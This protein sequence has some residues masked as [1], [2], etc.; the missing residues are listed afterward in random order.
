MQRTLPSPPPDAVERKSL[1]ETGFI[2]AEWWTY[3]CRRTGD[4]CGSA[5]VPRGWNMDADHDAISGE[6]LAQHA[7]C[8]ADAVNAQTEQA[9][10]SV[11]AEALVRFGTRFLDTLR[12]AA[13]AAGSPF[14]ELCNEAA[15]LFARWIAGERL[16]AR[17]DEPERRVRAAL[18]LLDSLDSSDLEQLAFLQRVAA[19]TVLALPQGHQERDA[20]RARDVLLAYLRRSRDKGDADEQVRTL[21][22]L[23]DH[24][25][26]FPEGIDSLV[27]EGL[28]LIDDARRA[29]SID[30]E[31]RRDF[32]TGTLLYYT[33]RL[34]QDPQEAADWRARVEAAIDRVLA[35]EP[36]PGDLYAANTYGSVARALEVLGRR[37]SAAEH[38]RR[39]VELGDLDKMTTQWAVEGECRM[40]MLLLAE[41]QEEQEREADFRRVTGLLTDAVPRLQERY[42]TAVLDEDIEKSGRL[43]AKALDYLAFA[44]ARQGA[45][46]DALRYLDIGKSLRLRHRYALRADPA[47]QSLL[48]LE[49]ALHAVLRGVP[50]EIFGV[51]EAEPTDVLGAASSAR[52]RL[53]EAYRATLPQLPEGLLKSPSI[54]DMACG[55]GEREAVVLLGV[56]M[57]GTVVA[58]ITREDR[59]TPSA[60][61]IDEHL[62]RGRWGKL[63]AGD[64]IER[65]WLAALALSEAADEDVAAY[66]SDVLDVLLGDTDRALGQRIGALLAG[67]GSERVTIIPH[68]LL[69]LIPFWALPGLEPFSL[70]VAPSAAQFLSARH[71]SDGGTMADAL[72][73][74]D[75]T[76]DL[77]LSPIEAGSVR[78]HL[79]GLGLRASELRG[80]QA[81]QQALEENLRGVGL[82]HISGHARSELFDPDRSGFLLHSGVPLGEDPFRPWL[83][84]SNDW[85][86]RDTRE[87]WAEIPGAGRL[88]ERTGLRPG[89]VERWMELDTTT[90]LYAHYSDER[91]TATAEIWSAG[92]IALSDCLRGCRL[93]FLSACES[94]MVSSD[95]DVDEYAGLPAALHLAGVETTIS[96]IWPVSQGTAALFVELFYE[97]FDATHGTVDAATLVHRTGRRLRSIRC[98]EAQDLLFELSDLAREQHPYAAL[99]MEAF[100]YRLPA[101]GDLPFA[102]SWEWASFHVT[103]TGRLH[104]S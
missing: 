20:E 88:Y 26:E 65:G 62:T 53:M 75:P 5:Y 3:S 8:I 15:L 60:Y 61:Y 32:R 66:Q 77:T 99:A 11:L 94:G 16:T 85:Q 98:E 79:G 43:L 101:R 24:W 21:C 37:R 9:R 58:V 80:S 103:G 17:S 71:R 2:A 92:D 97:R 6:E 39:A 102:R 38:Y 67:L 55:L 13:K 34:M 96:T 74:S 59:T 90:T 45:W 95:S 47:G 82:F 87:R 27:D 18:L 31:A 78:R 64:P 25:L 1:R 7:Q 70:A 46:D 40:R 35:D 91:L 12:R 86:E 72:I 28:A 48:K 83:A 100:A 52:T 104:P 54:R 51:E 50:T 4:R 19:A 68:K 81:V 84:A 76:E 57:L 41:S 23:R 30:P 29:E 22:V 42:L 49:A 36:P 69:H 89:E 33:Q 44:H 14:I 56:H 73:V 93:A 63:V 10:L